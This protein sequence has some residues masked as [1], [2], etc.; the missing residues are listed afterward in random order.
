VFHKSFD[1]PEK[2]RLFFSTIPES[3]ARQLHLPRQLNTQPYGGIMGIMS[4]NPEL[5][6]ISVRR[7]SLSFSEAVLVWKLRAT[8]EK[9]HVIAAML[10]TNAGRVAD[11]LTEKVHL[12][13]REA[14]VR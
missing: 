9:Q 1:S 13:A 11:V 7:T 6:T 14:S 4:S 10:G 5:N 2:T 8:G 3:E 12:G